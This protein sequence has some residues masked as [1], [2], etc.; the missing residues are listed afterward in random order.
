MVKSALES[1]QSNPD[2]DNP[3]PN[4]GDLPN[5]RLLPCEI[6]NE[7]RRRDSIIHP[8]SHSQVEVREFE[9][10]DIAQDTCAP[11]GAEVIEM[12]QHS[13]SNG[14][15]LNYFNEKIKLDNTSIERVHVN[16]QEENSSFQ[17]IASSSNHA[18]NIQVH[19]CIILNRKSTTIQSGSHLENDTQN[20][21]LASMNVVDNDINVEVK[22]STQVENVRKDIFLKTEGLSE[23]NNENRE[24]NSDI[25]I[26]EP[27]EGSESSYHPNT[28]SDSEDEAENVNRRKKF[29]AEPEEV[30]AVRVENNE[31]KKRQKKGKADP[32]S[33]ERNEQKYLRMRGKEYRSKK[34]E[35]DGSS[36]I[37]IKRNSREM[38][39]RCTSV[40]CLAAK[41]KRKCSMITD[42]Q[43]RK[44]FDGFWSEMDWHQRKLFVCT[45]VNHHPTTQKRTQTK[46]RRNFSLFYHLKIDNNVI[47]VCKKMFLST[48]G[49]GEWSVQ[50]WVKNSCDTG[51]PKITPTTVPTKIK[52]VN[53]ERRNTVRAFLEKLPKM[54]SHYCRSTTSK[55]YLETIFQSYKEV[56]D[57]YKKDEPESAVGY[58][59]FLKEM[60]NA[61][62]DVYHPRK[63]Q[64][65]LCFSHKLGNVEQRDYESHITQKDRARK[66]KIKDKEDALKGKVC[67]FTMDVQAVQLVP[68]VPAGMVYFKQ[69]LACHNFT[70]Y[71][72][73]NDRVVCYVWH[74]GEGKMDANSF[75][76]CIIDFLNE[77]LDDQ[78]KEKPKIFYSD[79]CSAQ[80]RN[81]T[82][83]NAF[84]H[85]CIENEMVII[86][87]Y[88][89]KGHSQME[90]DSVHSTIERK[91]KK[92]IYSP[93]NYVEIIKDARKNSK[94]PYK[95]KFIDHRFFNDYSEI[96][97]YSSIRPGRKVGDACVNNL[98]AL[99]YSKDLD[100]QYKLN[101]DEE[102]QFLP[103]R[104]NTNNAGNVKKIYNDHLPISEDKYNHLQSLKTVIHA[105]YHGFYDSLKH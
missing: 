20:R 12:Q 62:I 97:Y 38:K 79:G 34:K 5:F 24:Y 10:L 25:E 43:R 105:D 93:S 28:S 27:F 26:I 9:T 54:P 58:D 95:V 46:S 4:V 22:E 78:E 80:N 70:I 69:K 51:I 56:Y 90:C 50:N 83:A 49:L 45:L 104:K 98:R 39:P 19:S 87:K 11:G 65:D 92:C 32:S 1:L 85:F 86:Q 14:E 84:Q 33:W 81:V 37:T 15:N 47:P 67:V 17:Q 13:K 77:E 68:V 103:V 7:R 73:A 60:K 29:K 99:R 36:I 8:D 42:E 88:L 71:N 2:I 94:N 61:N 57:V 3:K 102:W 21:C 59:V 40:K 82:L 16:F 48:L 100:I 31:K 91:K 6:A 66:E 44:I 75:A 72:L 18:T 35:K 30:K 41:E 55:L 23:T 89:V 96:K 101:F 63:D 52:R 76:S 74:E 53:V 64:C